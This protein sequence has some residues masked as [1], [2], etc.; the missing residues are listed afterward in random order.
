[1]PRKFINNKQVVASPRNG[2]FNME[3]KYSVEAR[4][5]KIWNGLLKRKEDLR[6]ERNEAMQEL[7]KQILFEEVLKKDDDDRVFNAKLR[8]E[9]INRRA[10]ELKI[11]MDYIE[12]GDY[13]QIEV[14]F[15]EAM[16]EF[17]ECFI[18]ANEF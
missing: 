18:F 8:M 13:S 1:M 7:A 6:E 10:I 16:E 2:E 9:D 17:D 15:N 3:N 11:I 14:L 4:V 5:S 12:A